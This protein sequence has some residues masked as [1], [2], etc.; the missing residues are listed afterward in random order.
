[1]IYQNLAL[2]LAGNV[3]SGKSTLGSITAGKVVFRADTSPTSVTTAM[4]SVTLEESGY[5]VVDLPGADNAD[6]VS[7]ALIKEAMVQG[8]E[9][10]AHNQVL[11]CVFGVG[12][13]GKLRSADVNTCNMVQRSYGFTAKTTVV[14]VNNFNPQAASA[15]YKAD[16][17]AALCEALPWIDASRI[18]FMPH[19]DL[20]EVEAVNSAEA[21]T[22]RMQL[23]AL[24]DASDHVH[25]TMTA[26]LEDERERSERLLRE[27]AEQQQR[28]TEAAQARIRELE[29][30]AAAQRQRDAE[31]AA[32]H[33][34]HLNHLAA[35]AERARYEA[36][37][38]AELQ[39]YRQM[40]QMR[41]MMFQRSLFR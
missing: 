40:Q 30:Q 28:E 18:L 15:T 11:G 20:S 12:N 22:F 16:T 31:A 19:Q 10:V 5:Q 2:V 39:A 37:V 25:H 23:L 38:R 17:I 41:E 34:A 27:A 6:S 8:I 14:I 7:K 1:M 36:Q 21:I 13:G 29:E 26:P 24:L 4:A 35:E 33:Q 3:G 32:A 9:T